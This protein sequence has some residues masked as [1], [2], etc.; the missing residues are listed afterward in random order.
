MSEQITLLIGRTDITPYAQVAIHSRED[1]ML[2][3]HILAAQNVDIAPALGGALFTDLLENRTTEKY[4]TLL[5]GGTYLDTEGNS[6]KFQGLKAAISC[7]TYARYMLA[8]NAVDTP[9]GV[10][11]KTSEYSE[12]VDAKLLMTNASAKR[13]EGTHYLNETL[14]FIRANIEEYSLFTSGCKTAQQVFIHK[15]N[16]A[17]KI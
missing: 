1:E 7:Y 16:G 15:L 8:K 10:V 5:N 6:V 4:R 2:F 14:K 3:P 11:S 9:F 13:N 17:S 12:A